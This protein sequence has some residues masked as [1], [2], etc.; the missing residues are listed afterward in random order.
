MN[1][2]EVPPKSLGPNRRSDPVESFL[3]LPV[4][5]DRALQDPMQGELWRCGAVADRNLY[6]GC[7]GVPASGEIGEP[8]EA[9]VSNG[10]YEGKRLGKGTVAVDGDDRSGV[11]MRDRGRLTAQV[12]CIGAAKSNHPRTPANM[13]KKKA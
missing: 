11:G 2:D 8:R 6:P 1:Q 10:K 12:T 7:R 3:L 9:G 5:R 13:L 4:E